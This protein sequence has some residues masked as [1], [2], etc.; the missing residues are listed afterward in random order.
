MWLEIL[1]RKTIPTNGSASVHYQ[2]LAYCD[3]YVH[4]ERPRVEFMNYLRKDIHK[5]KKEGDQS[6]FMEDINE[7]ILYTK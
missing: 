1:Y 3:R 4:K 5:W 2:Y 7:Y 6:I